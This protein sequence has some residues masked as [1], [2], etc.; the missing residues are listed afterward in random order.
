MIHSSL[1]IIKE[2]HASLAA[3]LRSLSMMIKRGPGDKPDVFFDVLRAMLFYID[4]VPE[5]QHHPKET[6]LLFPK[7][8][9]RYP[10]IRGVIERLDRDHGESEHSV[11][12]LQHQLLAWELLGESRRDVFV[13]AATR[14]VDAYLEHM[15]L[16]E[17]QVLPA[18]VKYLDETD[19]QELNAA[20]EQNQDPLSKSQPRDPIYEN[21]F[22]R[23]LMQAPEPI[24][25]GPS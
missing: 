15:H 21:L 7:I 11:R 3:M 25:L 4:E 8:T 13:S 5:Q 23:I 16:E 18:A 10:D 17:Q 9:S 19:W 14:Y 20:F 1:R 24:G 6:A 2:E 12:V 22:T